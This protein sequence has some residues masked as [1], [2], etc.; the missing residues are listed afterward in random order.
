MKHKHNM[1]NGKGLESNPDRGPPMKE[2]PHH[3]DKGYTSDHD[4]FSPPKEYPGDH[5]R[6]NQYMKHQNEI[7]SRDS[8]KLRREQFTKI[9]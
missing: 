9:A 2:G 4:H 6:G 3:F 8:K 7:I 5:E 1:A